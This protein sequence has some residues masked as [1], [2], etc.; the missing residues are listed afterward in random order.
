MVLGKHHEVWPTMRR[1][2]ETRGRI[3]AL[4]DIRLRLIEM[5]ETA[6]ADAAAA[7]I[8]RLRKGLDYHRHLLIAVQARLARSRAETE[9]PNAGR[10]PH[11]PT[12]PPTPLRRPVPRNSLG[13]AREAE[14]AA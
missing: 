1:I 13:A 10:P 14:D 4:E 2:A 7:Q 12:Y 8:D 9:G 6:S 3:A 11:G 5:G